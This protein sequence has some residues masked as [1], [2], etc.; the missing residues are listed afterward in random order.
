MIKQLITCFFKTIEKKE[1]K[2]T[3][4]SKA[5]FWANELQD[6]DFNHENY[7]GKRKAERY[8]EKYIEE[9]P[10]VSVTDPNKYQ[11]DFM[12]KYSGYLDY[13]DFQLKNSNII[14]DGT[15][16]NIRNKETSI[17]IT[18]PA[19]SSRTNSIKQKVIITISITLLSVSSFIFFKRDYFFNTGNCIV[20]N[21]DHYERTVCTTEGAISDTLYHI[22]IAHFKKVVLTKNMEF[23]TEGVPNYWYGSNNQG[24]RE[25]FTA[26]GIHPETK[27]ELDEITEYILVQEGLIN[28]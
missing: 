10:N 6:V 2:N 27:R 25:F 9:K 21:Q 14:K 7:I 20:W 5:T 12:S 11:R 13:E 4:N 28:Y 15:I 8:Y 26:R 3:K 23:F 19:T 24:K 17:N 18:K 22:D 16:E 1:F